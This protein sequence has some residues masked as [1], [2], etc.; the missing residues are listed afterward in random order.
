MVSSG[1][2]YRFSSSCIFSSEGGG[3]EINFTTQPPLTTEP[4]GGTAWMHVARMFRPKPFLSA[5]GA[6]SGATPLLGG[7]AGA[8]GF[9]RPASICSL[10][11][12]CGACG[13]GICGL[14]PLLGAVG[15][16][17]FDRA[18]VSWWLGDGAC[19]GGIGLSC[20]TGAFT[21]SRHAVKLLRSICCC[22]FCCCWWGSWPVDPD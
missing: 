1:F 9:V 19:G 14:K 22:C 20:G 7:G 17:G 8:G 10:G 12:L 11:G 21:S 3:I 6:W 5:P 2:L 4:A 13:G 18:S 15:T 16:G